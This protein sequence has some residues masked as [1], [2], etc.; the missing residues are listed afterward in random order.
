[1]IRALFRSLA[2]PAMTAALFH[3]ASPHRAG[4]TDIITTL[5]GG[6]SLEGYQPEE[7]NLA[8]GASQGLAISSR[9]EIYFSDSAHNQVLKVNA[10]TALITIVAGNGAQ[11]YGGDGLPAPSASLNAPGGLALDAAGNLLIADRGNFSVR[12]VDALS[13]VISTVA[14][15]GLFTGQ[16]V[17]N[18]PPALLGD[19]GSAVTATFGNLG[20][21]VVDGTGAVI[22]SDSGNACVRKFTIGGTIS[23]IAGTPGSSGFTGDGVGG[24]ALS[25]KFNAPTGVALDGAGSIY[26]ADSGNRRVRRLTADATVTTVAGSGTGGNTGFTGDGGLPVTAQI[27]SLGG[28][29][30]NAAGELVFSCVGANRI[31]KATVNAVVPIITTIAGNGGADVLGDGGPATGA[32]LSAPRDIVLDAKGNTIIYDAGHRRLRR[33]DQATSFIDT[34]VGSGLIG[35]IG[36]RGPKQSG[37]LTNPSG[38]AFD[39]AGNLYIADRGNN[40]VRKI[41]LDGT[42]TTFA[43][44]GTNSGLGDGG[45]AVL[46]TLAGPT[47]V[48]VFGTTLFIADNGNDRIRAVDLGTGLIRT[49]ASVSAPQAIIANSSGVLYV[50]HDDQVDTVDL[51]GTVT[52][53][54]GDNPM[55]SAGNPLGDGLPATNATL[56]APHGLALDAAGELFIADTGNDRIRRVAAPPGLLVSTVAGGGNLGFPAIGDGGSPTAAVLNA[57]VGVAV[58]ATRILIADTGNHRIRS[59]TGGLI[60]TICGTGFARFNNDGDLA[61]NAEVNLPGLITF[62]GAN[63]VIADTNN[64]RIRQIVPALDIDLKRLSFSALLHF[65]VNKKTGQVARGLDKA[66]VK[67]TLALPAGI[68]TANLDIHVDIVDLHQQTQFT[69][70]GRQ[71][72]PVRRPII[73]TTPFDFTLPSP[74]PPL[75]SKYTLVLKGTSVAGGKPV[76]FSFSTAGTLREELG[77]AGYTDVSI[78]PP[79]LSLP[80]RVNISLGQT[81]FTGLA[82]TKYKAKQGKTGT[83]VTLK[84]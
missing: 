28:I 17:G 52:P 8:L 68:S 37:V 44:D 80:V 62:H 47:D 59:A 46:A 5:A 40:A 60:N 63:L 25:A 19:G 76:P 22:V 84:P 11:A 38:A 32:S 83:V 50:S 65:A 56:S 53:F 45:P 48:L 42:I 3:L 10:T 18:N 49:Y 81:T 29:A 15:I 64:N 77:R 66:S 4:A 57:P 20:S 55:D 67:A 26:I 16:V 23:T 7:A 43:G 78:A 14:G 24:G 79:G 39:A 12:R 27:G 61:V 54:A 71:P 33:V 1:M 6:G 58:D 75:K 31:R 13:G 35:F 34:I 69:A 70:K 30:F 9:G 73:V 51:T 74:P 21:L 72:L 2:V 41:A 82:A 36:D